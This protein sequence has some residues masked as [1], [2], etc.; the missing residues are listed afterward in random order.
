MDHL[1]RAAFR[2]LLDVALEDTGQ[3]RRVSNFIMA[4]WNA[5]SLGGFDL[6]DL[7]VV[8]KSIAADMARV[9]THLGRLAVAEYPDEF[10]PEIE[11][12]I[13]RWRP[14]VWARATASDVA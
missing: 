10:H 9:F 13:A 5:E 12:L 8:D 11:R 4:W 1:T 14:E 2:R 6:A 7:F 3:S